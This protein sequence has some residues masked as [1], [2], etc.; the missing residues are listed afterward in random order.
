MSD[1]EVI[2]GYGSVQY[3][4]KVDEVPTTSTTEGNTT[5]NVIGTPE[6]PEYFGVTFYITGRVKDGGPLDSNSFFWTE[7]VHG[8]AS[9]TPYAEVET[10]AAKQLAASLRSVADAVATS[11]GLDGEQDA[12]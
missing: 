8:L 12:S 9:N 5:V 11:A 4:N 3:F 6:I 2:V 7:K 10:K 1:L